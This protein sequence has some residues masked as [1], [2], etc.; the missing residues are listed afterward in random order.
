M[1]FTQTNSTSATL[2]EVQLSRG[3]QIRLEPGAMVYKDRDIDLKGKMNGGLF[4]AI[5][6]SITGG[7]SFFTTVATA[8]TDGKLAIAPRGFGNIK[9]LSTT[10]NQW[11][12]RDG[13]FLACD[14]TVNYKSKRHG[15]IGRALLG[16]TGGFFILKTEGNGDILVNG[17]GDLLE[18][19][20]DGSKPF[21][22]DNGHVV[23]WEDTLDYRLETASGLIGFKTGEGYV[24]T[25]TGRGKV[26]IQTRQIEAF[27]EML[28]PFLPT[29]QP[30]R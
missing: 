23:A 17:F 12:L 9:C 10:N 25:F 18:I 8:E 3:E 30:A 4:S 22:I 6:K 27:A 26:I 28:I 21:Q 5:G 13:A 15:G 11:F 1:K 7:E 24:N 29:Q 16:G 14:G 2:V 20:L 19:E